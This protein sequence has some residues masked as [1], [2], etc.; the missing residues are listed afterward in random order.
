[1]QIPAK[2][3][4]LIQAKMYDHA[5]LAGD[6]ALF[7]GWVHAESRWNH[8][9]MRHEPAFLRTYVEPIPGL[10][11]TEKIGRATSWG[12]LQIMGQTAREFGFTGKYLPELCDPETNLDLACQILKTRFAIDGNWDGALARYNG[13]L[14]GNN[15]PPYRNAHYVMTVHSRAEMYR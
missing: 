14:L 5:V 2:Y 4:P 8:Y 10:S 15:V 6:V 11:P 1:M 12:L 9:A 3:L 13:G 7:A